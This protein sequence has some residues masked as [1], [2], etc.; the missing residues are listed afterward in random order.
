MGGDN[1][2]GDIKTYYNLLQEFLNK[3][4]IK[5]AAPSNWCS[6]SSFFNICS[7]NSF[8]VNFDAPLFNNYPGLG[9]LLKKV[10]SSVAL[11]CSRN[12][13]FADTQEL[14]EREF[15]AWIDEV[16]RIFTFGLNTELLTQIACE[17]YEGRIAKELSIVFI[18]GQTVLSQVSSNT[19][20][21]D[22]HIKLPIDTE[23]V[24]GIRKLLE[25]AQNGFSLL[26]QPSS[27]GV[28]A[29]GF[30]KRGDF[31]THFFEV[32]FEGKMRWA[33]Y[34]PNRLNVKNRYPLFRY[35]NGLLVFPEIDLNSLLTEKALSIFPNLNRPA[36]E[37]M[38]KLAQSQHHGTIVIWL[39][40]R[41]AKKEAK[42]LCI[43]GN[44]GFVPTKAIQH[45]NKKL[46]SAIMAIDGALLCGTKSGNCIA[47]GVI[48]DGKATK[49]GTRERGARYNSAQSYI[50]KFQSSWPK[51]LAIV[52]SEDGMIDAITT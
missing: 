33:F 51:A 43:R 1:V 10:V 49:N 18:P 26:A 32:C 36:F 15:E 24:H 23:H 34:P 12:T 3:H 2:T 29:I 44:Q 14:L 42:R 52:V 6:V 31:N 28:Y 27:S 17:A 37:R 41:I 9:F 13:S 45:R 22:K 40:D 19:T 50:H 16:V 35:C 48:L 7:N 5:P 21:L 39:P 8:T 46:I 4:G 25:I 38:V 11:A 20:V 47:Y 30:G